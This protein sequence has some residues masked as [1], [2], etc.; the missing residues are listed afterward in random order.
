MF[1][2]TS[3]KLN[4]QSVVDNYTMVKKDYQWAVDNDFWFDYVHDIDVSGDIDPNVFTRNGNFWKVVPLILKGQALEFIPAQLKNSFTVNTLLSLD[5]KPVLAIFSILDPHSD[6]DPHSDHDDEIVLD[7]KH[8]PHNER[9]DSVVKYH[10]GLDVHNDGPAGLV[11]DDID[12]P[13]QE[14]VLSAFNETTVHW[15]YNHTSKSRGVLIVS[16]L[17]SQL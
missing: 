12:Q 15:A 10:L 2:T 1:V 7:T 5:V 11:V 8:I 16:Y 17:K 9:N 13:V 3:D 4:F 6:I 14:G